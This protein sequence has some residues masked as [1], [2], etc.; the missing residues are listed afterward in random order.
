MVKR[1]FT[2]TY[3]GLG[4]ALLVGLM[5][6]LLSPAG[7]RASLIVSVGSATAAP[8]SSGNGLDVELSNTGP[9]AVTI[10]AFSFGVITP[11]LNISF[12]DANTST[13]SSPYIFVGNS[14]FGPDLTGPTSGQSL[15][16]SDVFATVLAGATLNAGTTVGLGHLLFNVSSAAT[17]GVSPVTLSAFPVTSL[18]DPTGNNVAFQTLSPGQITITGAAAVPEPSTAVMLLFGALLT[19]GLARKKYRLLAARGSRSVPQ[20]LA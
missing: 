15:A 3:A 17:G 11:N 10:A 14:L 2:G 18:A 20:D 8:G 1:N 4:K 16:T 5:V 13:V 12:T 19:A 7:A 6:L 9:S